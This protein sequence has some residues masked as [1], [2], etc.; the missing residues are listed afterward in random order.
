MRFLSD[1]LRT[2]GRKLGTLVRETSSW[3]SFWTTLSPSHEI[4]YYSSGGS[5]GSG[6]GPSPRE[7]EL[8]KALKDKVRQCATLQSNLDRVARGESARSPPP[9]LGPQYRAL[10]ESLRATATHTAAT[11]QGEV[12]AEKEEREVRE[13]RAATAGG[14]YPPGRY[15]R[16][17]GSGSAEPRRLCG[18]TTPRWP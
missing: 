3:T 4:K 10:V 11:T 5:S 1:E 12:R 15:M 18:L 7:Q 14:D 16:R 13:E 8:Q 6:S 17:H 9:G 2:S